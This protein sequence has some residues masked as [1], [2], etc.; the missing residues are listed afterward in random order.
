MINE[1]EW[2][3]S[4]YSRRQKLVFFKNKSTTISCHSITIVGSSYYHWI[5]NLCTIT[6]TVPLSCLVPL[7]STF[8]HSFV[9]CVSPEWRENMHHRYIQP[10]DKY[11]Q[12]YMKMTC[13]LVKLRVNCLLLK[14]YRKLRQMFLSPKFWRILDTNCA[15]AFYFCPT[16]LF[17]VAFCVLQDY[18][19]SICSRQ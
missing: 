15:I 14:F 18:D 10:L 19:D 4:I 13:S 8:C 6:S 17:L 12:I 2:N 1:V 9:S 5:C 16:G 11:G 7:P 3:Y